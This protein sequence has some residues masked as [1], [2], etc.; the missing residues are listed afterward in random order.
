[1]EL[2][3]E[4]E[5]CKA[6]V[7]ESRASADENRAVAELIYEENKT[8]MID[9]ST[10]D[11]YTRELWDLTRMEILQ[12]GREE[13]TTRAAVTSGGAMESG[14]GTGLTASGGG[15]GGIDDPASVGAA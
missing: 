12:S 1:M 9:P 14:G 5:K 13:A 4:D 15:G 8:M 11:A 6:A 2:L 7:K 10:M 3:Q